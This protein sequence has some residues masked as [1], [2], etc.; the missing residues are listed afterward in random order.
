MRNAPREI[1]LLV[2]GNGRAPF[3]EFY[4]DLR[5]SQARIAIR[6]RLLRVAHGLLGTVR[7]LQGGVS[8]LK[9]DIGPGYRVYFAEIEGR[10]LVLLGAGQKRT[11][12]QDIDRAVELWTQYREIV[13]KELKA[14][15]A[16]QKSVR[17]YQ[18]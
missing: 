9:F 4:T 18:G 11:Q 6:N 15:E 8:E 1:Y 5:D 16:S 7:P 14:D 3:E 2:L 13:A 17:R 12:Q 10:I